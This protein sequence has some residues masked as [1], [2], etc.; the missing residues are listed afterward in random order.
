MSQSQLELI[1]LTPEKELFRGEVENVTLPGS[2]GKFEVLI[3][4][5]PL[6]SS[7]EKGII[8]YTIDGEKHQTEISGGFVEVN[9]NKVNVCVELQ[10]Q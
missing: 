5:A 4:H 6:I 7:L 2:K 3:N 8:E 10:M 9:N 1:I